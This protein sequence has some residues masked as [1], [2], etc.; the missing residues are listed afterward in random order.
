MYIYVHTH[1]HTHTPHFFHTLFHYGLSQNSEY[2]S[3]WDTVGPW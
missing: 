1:T 2:S 3:P